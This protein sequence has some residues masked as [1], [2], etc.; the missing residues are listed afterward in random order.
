MSDLLAARSPAERFAMACRM[1]DAAQTLARAGI[2]AE[3]GPGADAHMRKYLFLRFYGQ[4]FAE[5]RKRRV[6]ASW[7]EDHET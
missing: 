6:L 1:F 4:D 7:G 2:I 5:E 3:H